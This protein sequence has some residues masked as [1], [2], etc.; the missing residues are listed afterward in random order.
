[1]SVCITR[2]IQSVLL[3]EKPLVKLT[4]GRFVAELTL[5][6]AIIFSAYPCMLEH[7]NTD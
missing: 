3:E 1:M 5:D 2:R 6:G 4:A 7:V